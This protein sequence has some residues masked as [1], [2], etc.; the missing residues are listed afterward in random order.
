MAILKQGRMRP[1]TTVQD[2][3]KNIDAIYLSISMSQLH[4]EN[5]D[6]IAGLLE[7]PGR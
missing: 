4:L 2:Q 6:E 1:C 7:L 5:G 3:S